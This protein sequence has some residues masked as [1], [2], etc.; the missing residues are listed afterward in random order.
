MPSEGDVAPGFTLMLDSGESVSLSDFFGKKVVLYFYSR[1]GTPGC[2]QEA[3]EFR[4]LAK[5][6]EKKKAVIIG[7]SKDSVESHR[8]SERTITYLSCSS[9]TLMERCLR[10]TE[11][12]RRVSTVEPSLG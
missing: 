10:H 2:T 11:F 6:F 1:D 7:I 12:G 3:R 4:D 8:R 5:E 9:V